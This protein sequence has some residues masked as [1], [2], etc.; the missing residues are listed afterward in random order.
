MPAYYNVVFLL[1]FSTHS[2][3]YYT[4]MIRTIHSN[5]F[6]S[7]NYVFSSMPL[8]RRTP[9]HCYETIG[10]SQWG[11]IEW[12]AVYNKPGEVPIDGIAFYNNRYCGLKKTTIQPPPRKPVAVVVFKNN[13]HNNQGGEKEEGGEGVYGIKL[14]NFKRLGIQ[15]NRGSYISFNVTEELA[16]RDTNPNSL[17]AELPAGDTVENGVYVWEGDS[18]DLKRPGK[19][20]V[21][22]PNSVDTIP[23]PTDILQRVDLEGDRIGYIY[24]RDLIERY[25]IGAERAEGIVD[26]V[27]PWVED[28]L[29]SVNDESLR[30]KSPSVVLRGPLYERGSGKGYKYANNENAWEV[31]R[32]PEEFGEPGRK[33]RNGRSVRYPVVREGSVPGMVYFERGGY[34]EEV[35]G[36]RRVEEEPDDVS[37]N[38]GVVREFRDFLDA[39]EEEEEEGVSEP[40]MGIDYTRKPHPELLTGI[41][42]ETDHNVDAQGFLRPK[43]RGRGHRPPARK[44]V[45][46]V[47]PIVEED[48]VEDTGVDFSMQI[49]AGSDDIFLE[50]EEPKVVDTQRVI[51]PPPSHHQNP[52]DRNDNNNEE[53]DTTEVLNFM[54]PISN[55]PVMANPS[56]R[57]T[58]G[59]H[60]SL[61]WTGNS[62]IDNRL[63]QYSPLASLEE[64]LPILS[65]STGR[66]VSF[67]TSM[68]DSFEDPVIMSSTGRR[69]RNLN[70]DALD[71]L[72]DEPDEED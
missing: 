27:T 37:I 18:R 48:D 19:H 66:G 68:E 30:K 5:W 36:S 34:Q 44:K 35:R 33:G 47:L 45:S 52:L 6:K 55:D 41:A 15:F 24:L 9:S 12:F 70:Q 20:I 21:Y 38:S 32:R 40:V 43:K 22:F 3:A 72:L 57:D 11:D 50:D 13:N 29:A 69:P 1:L 4:T 71:V 51:P 67:P 61:D 54:S 62:N 64:T 60:T 23:E 17:F 56:S 46:K 42:R 63:G 8:N 39:D 58:Q 65:T 7:F 10:R 16:K 14:I 26:N 53:E 28:R 25:L 49:E 59:L 31:E 2:A